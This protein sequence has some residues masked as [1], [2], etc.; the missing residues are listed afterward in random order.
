MF[1]FDGEYYI[2]IEKKNEKESTFLGYLFEND[3]NRVFFL[4]FLLFGTLVFVQTLALDVSLQLA[5]LKVRLNGS[6]N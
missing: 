4:T 2:H 5:K 6:R 1:R 3:Y